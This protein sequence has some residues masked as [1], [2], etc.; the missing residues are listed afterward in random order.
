MINHHMSGRGSSV[1]MHDSSLGLMQFHDHHQYM[2]GSSTGPFL[3]QHHGFIHAEE[4]RCTGK[5][6]PGLVEP[7]AAGVAEEV[8]FDACK[9]GGGDVAVVGQERQQQEDAPK[10]GEEEKEAHGVRMIALLMEC[11]VAMSVG[12]LA[13]A[14][15]TLLELSQMA[16]PYAPSCGERL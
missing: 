13:D 8:E 16:S 15:G 4:D 10:Q 11:A 7:A 9:E 6:V 14:N 12:N 1:D 3:P 5:V 2:Y